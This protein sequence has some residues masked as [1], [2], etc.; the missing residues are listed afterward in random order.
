MAGNLNAILNV[1]GTRLY[2]LIAYRGLCS[3]SGNHP[4][5][6]RNPQQR[7]TMYCETASIVTSWSL[8]PSH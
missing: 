1:V 2:T 3:I 5:S 7:F 8:M 4:E 6:P